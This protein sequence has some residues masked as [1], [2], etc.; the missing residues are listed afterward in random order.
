MARVGQKRNFASL[1]AFL[2]IGSAETAT[3]FGKT[4][5]AAS[6]WKA[7]NNNTPPELAEQWRKEDEDL[8]AYIEASVPAVLDHTGSEAFDEHLRGVQSIL[9]YWSA[10]NYLYNAGLFHSIYGTEGFQ[11]FSMPLSE[12]ESIRGLIGEKAERL[13][14]IFCMVDRSTVDATVFDWKQSDVDDDSKE[15]TFKARPELGRFDIKLSKNEWVD[16]IELTLADWLEQVQGASEKPSSLFLWGA[17]EAYAYRRKAYAKI[18]QILSSER[19]ER[20]KNVTKEMFAA[21]YG[22]ENLSTRHLVQPRTPPMSEAAKQAMDALRSA[23]EDITMDFS[24]QPVLDE[25]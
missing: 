19:R 20:L 18:S 15:Y 3:A 25:L 10:P 5:H 6:H 17:G 11:G 8:H 22:T 13:C 16:F 21:V 14:W 12:R 7:P 2:S 23:G 9:R 24:P 4:Y 1:M